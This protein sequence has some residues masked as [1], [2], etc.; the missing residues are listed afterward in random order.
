MTE[1]RKA[2][3][4]RYEEKNRFEFK[5]IS[6]KI[7]KAQRGN[8]KKRG[9]EMPEWNLEELR[10]WLQKQPN[11]NSLMEGYRAS[12]GHSD[13]IPSVDRKKDELPYTF[14][15]IQL[16][17]FR[18]NYMRNIKN[19]SKPVIQMTLEGEFIKEWK[20]CREVERELGIF[21]TS[22]AAVCRGSKYRKTSGGFMWKYE[23]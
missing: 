9:H 10:S 14:D 12:G 17:T 7:H 4:K 19:L 15:N 11:L 13:F 22:I 18:E 20:S 23:D 3:L 8:S 6:N 1:A 16:G 21:S 5:F 2:Y